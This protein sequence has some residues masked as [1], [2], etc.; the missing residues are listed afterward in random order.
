MPRPVLPVAAFPSHT[1]A[2]T[3]AD[4]LDTD[5]LRIGDVQLVARLG[6]GG[7]GVVYLGRTDAGEAVAVKVVRAQI[8][9]DPDFRRRFAD[10]VGALRGLGGAYTARVLDADLQATPQWFVMEYVQGPTLA[11]R[12]ARSGPL[13]V[14]EARVL[15]AELAAALAQMQAVGIVHRDLKPSNV[16][17]SP[18]G[19]KLIDFGVAMGMGSDADAGLRV[20]SLS[21]MA[22]EQIAGAP[23]GAPTDIHA[24]AMLVY[25]AACGRPVYGYG[26]AEAVAW[27]IGHTDPQLV[28]LPSELAD[29]DPA[30]REALHK[31]PAQR[32]SAARVRQ[33]L[34]PTAPPELPDIPALL[35]PPEGASAGS[36][37][38]AAGP[39]K[40]RR[41]WRGGLAL[42]AL[43]WLV[44]WVAGGWNLVPWMSSDLPGTTGC[45][46]STAEFASGQGYATSGGG[47]ARNAWWGP[48]P[49]L[50]GAFRTPTETVACQIGAG[51]RLTCPAATMGALQMNE[52]TATDN[53]GQ[54]AAVHLGRVGP[55][56]GWT[57]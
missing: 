36:V 7:M 42:V 10:E 19:A 5:P 40:R 27:R 55:K 31:D 32:P 34:D 1:S 2:V 22:P 37:A 25:F 41:W 28:D 3:T 51:V 17:L 11:A 9:A 44:G 39:P 45:T 16:V 21:W 20:G 13:S 52:C 57:I 4:L 6:E 49:G 15:A 53:S 43:V 26:D 50:F 18:D 24:L 47:P 14:D 23:A 46:T 8:A 30:L 56:W 35:A 38:D 54:T 29:F 33:L 48:F 12:V